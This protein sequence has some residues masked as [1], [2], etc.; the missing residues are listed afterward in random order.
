MAYERPLLVKLH[1]DASRFA[2]N[3]CTGRA[4]NE[5]DVAFHFNPRLDQN[6]VA[7]NDKKDGNWGM[8]DAQPLIVMQEDS[9]AVKVFNPGHTTQILIESEASH[10]KVS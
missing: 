3:F 8:E 10:L 7:L 4:T 9:S 1:E 2:L 5:A 6:K